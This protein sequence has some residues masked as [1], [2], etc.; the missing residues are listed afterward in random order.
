MEFLGT[1]SADLYHNGHEQ[2]KIKVDDCITS[3]N[4]CI[5]WTLENDNPTT[6]LYELYDYFKKYFAKKANYFKNV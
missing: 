2:N 4:V 1:E 5:Q 6:A 3:T